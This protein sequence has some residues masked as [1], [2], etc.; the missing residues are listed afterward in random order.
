[1]NQDSLYKEDEMLFWEN[2]FSEVDKFL[3]EM[4]ANIMVKL[5]EI[6]EMIEK[7]KKEGIKIYEKNHMAKERIGKLI[8]GNKALRDELNT[9]T[10][11]KAELAGKVDVLTKQKKELEENI[12]HLTQ[13]KSDLEKEWKEEKKRLTEEKE[14]LEEEKARLKEQNKGLTGQKEQLKK[15]NGDLAVGNRKLRETRDNLQ[16]EMP[17]VLQLREV[18][19]EIVNLL[20][21]KG[22]TE[23]FPEDPFANLYMGPDGYFED[24]LSK[25]LDPEFPGW[26]CQN[27]DA[28]VAACQSGSAVVYEAMTEV[29]SGLNRLLDA[30]FDLGGKSFTE[31]GIRRLQIRKGE[32]LREDCCTYING[33][34]P[35]GDNKI[36]IVWMNGIEDERNHR[37]YRSFVEGDW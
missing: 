33:G 31:K 9:L 28:F 6:M 18:Y 32:L 11:E 17:A 25:S 5:R 4:D 34:V 2:A 30:V 15:E 1:M 29:L 22:R 7:N 27:A 16:E 14:K 21:A 35:Y 20:I 19:H 26:Y 8:V 36:K 24:F 13:E 37:I 10:A 12:A 23:G 3:L